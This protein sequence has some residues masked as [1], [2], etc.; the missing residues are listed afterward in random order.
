MAPK[1]KLSAYSSQLST[2]RL[3]WVVNLHPSGAE[4]LKLESGANARSAKYKANFQS[5]NNQPTV[6]QQPIRGSAPA[7]TRVLHFHVRLK[8][9]C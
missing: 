6:F 9:L 8:P 5:I 4:W 3:D 7:Y 1:F 2:M